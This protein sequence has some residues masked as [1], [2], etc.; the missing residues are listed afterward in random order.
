V[1]EAKDRNRVT[2]EGKAAWFQMVRLTE[3]AI[4]QLT[5]EGEPDERCKSCAFRLGTVP[6]GCIQTQADAMKAVIE[7]VPFLCHQADRKGWP[8]HG[9]F[10]ARVAIQ[11]AEK[12][13]GTKLD[14]KCPWEFSP[15]DEV[16]P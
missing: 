12:A 7:G 2:P 13:R 8:C 14:V 11:R 16:S 3:P 1:K 10:A 15:P 9:W 4:T 5:S 6:N